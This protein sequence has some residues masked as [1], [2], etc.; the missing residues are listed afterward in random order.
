[1]RLVAIL[2]AGFA[3]LAPGELAAQQESPASH[4]HL[5]TLFAGAAASSERHETAVVIGPTYKFQLTRRVAVGPVIEMTCYRTE[6]S[7]LAL[8]GVFLRPFRAMEM[9][10]APGVEW[11]TATV[12]SDESV[13]ERGTFAFRVGLGYRLLM[14]RGYSVVPQAAV[15]VGSGVVTTMYGLA[16]GI[17]F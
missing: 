7:T 11:I 9:T 15:N 3:L 2:T 5:I 4:R 12:D 8:A 14:Q 1:M 6:T 13:V 10:L 17:S 16:F